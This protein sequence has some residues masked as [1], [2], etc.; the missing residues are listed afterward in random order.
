MK[1][2][3]CRA[4]LRPPNA[5]TGEDQ[6]YQ[7][8]NLDLEDLSPSALESEIW[9]AARIAA[10]DPRKFVWRGMEH[11]SA[12][13]WADQRIALCRELLRQSIPQSPERGDPELVAAGRWSAWRS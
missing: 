9:R 3:A 6:W 5:A 8:Y 10:R 7:V 2:P 13:Q 11:I 1:A 4:R 12:R